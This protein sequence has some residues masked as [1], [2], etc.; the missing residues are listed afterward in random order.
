MEGVLALATIARDW[1]LQLP[2]GAPE[3]LPL[4]AKITLRPLGGMRLKLER[5]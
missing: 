5:R 3:T 1:T 2:P 4:D